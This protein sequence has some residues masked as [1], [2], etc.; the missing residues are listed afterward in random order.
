MRGRKERRED[1]KEKIEL[2]LL[3]KRLV[4]AVPTN[5]I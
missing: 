2:I 3:K 4:H 1:Y 5:P